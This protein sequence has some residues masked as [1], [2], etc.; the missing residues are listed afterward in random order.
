MTISASDTYLLGVY[1]PFVEDLAAYDISLQIDG[2]AQALASAYGA[3]F[4]GQG[5]ML[6]LYN[7]PSPERSGALL[8]DTNATGGGDLAWFLIGPTGLGDVSISI[9]P[10]S[11]L[12]DDCGEPIFTTSYTVT[13]HQVPEPATLTVLAAGITILGTL[14]RRRKR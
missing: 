3:W 1:V 7:P 14:A 12:G 2:P 4:S 10:D 8:L 5:S 6:G 11:I 9:S 13:V